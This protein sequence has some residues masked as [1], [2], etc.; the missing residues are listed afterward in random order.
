[1]NDEEL[2]NYAK[3][4]YYQKSLVLVDLN[5]INDPFFKQELINYFNGKYHK[6]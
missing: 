5:D 6:K 1:M 2:H 4:A 3:R